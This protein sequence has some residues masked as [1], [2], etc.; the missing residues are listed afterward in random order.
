MSASIIVF[1]VGVVVYG[2]IINLREVSLDVTIKEKELGELENVSFLIDRHN[3]R[4]EL[5]SDGIFV[6]SYKAVFG[7]NKNSVKISKDDLVTPTGEYFICSIDTNYKYHKLLKI[8]YP[9]KRDASEAYKNGI[10]N[11]EEFS[12]IDESARNSDCSPE[13]TK[14]G[15]DIGI[16]GIGTY[17]FIFKNL[18]FVYN[19]TNGSIAVCNEDIDELYSVAEIG[20]KVFIRN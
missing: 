7:K 13:N 3:Y 15:A 16:H 5:Y 20:T 19:W 1:F 9:N 10:I 14:L 12:E 2:I 4:L 18:P 17:N 8:N 6:K 11:K